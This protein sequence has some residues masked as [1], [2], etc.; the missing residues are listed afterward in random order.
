MILDVFYPPV[1]MLLSF[2][3]FKSYPGFDLPIMADLRCDY[4][5]GGN[6]SASLL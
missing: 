4:M 2:V 1:H 5:N 3:P 6:L